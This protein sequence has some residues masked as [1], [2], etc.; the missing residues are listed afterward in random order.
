MF[1]DSSSS[2]CESWD[3]RILIKIT[4]FNKADAVIRRGYASE[5][6]ELKTALEGMPLHMK[7]SDQAGKQGMPIFDPVG[8]NEAIK[9]AIMPHGWMRLPIPPEFN[10]LGIDVDF[11]K[12]GVIAECS[13]ATT[14]FC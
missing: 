9:A 14:R 10:F 3:A 1:Y 8:T 6:E 12:R 4:D 7:A 13:S 2:Y 11:G 5:W